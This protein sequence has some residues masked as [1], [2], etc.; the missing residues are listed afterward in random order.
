MVQ[1]NDENIAMLFSMG[2]DHEQALQALDDS[3]GNVER[4]LDS[5]LGG[6]DEGLSGAG[7]APL[8][9]AGIITHGDVRA[10]HSEISQYNDPMGRS[11]CTSIALTMAL[12]VLSQ[13]HA[14]DSAVPPDEF[15]DASFLST[16][17][18]EGIQL[19]SKLRNNS[20][21]EHLSVEEV[22]GANNKSFASLSMLG[23]S[24]RQGILDS[25]NDLSPMGLEAVLSQCQAEATNP[26]SFSAIVLTKPPETVLVVLPPASS[27]SQTYALLDSHPRPNQLPPHNPAGSY[28]L[29]H[30]NLQSLVQSLKE[31]FPATNLGSDV[32]EIMAMMYNSFDVYTFQ[33]R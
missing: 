17:I 7:G 26:N 8:P 28:V 12:K 5:L 31:I 24:P 30:P 25:T 10:V 20:G 27:N 16:S 2:F 4:A 14:C 9:F 18:Q 21:V 22:L 11:A 29:F 13:L 19:F 15:V 32:P 23:N 33:H 3:G 1:S 6:G